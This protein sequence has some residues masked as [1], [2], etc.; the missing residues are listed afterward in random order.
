MRTTIDLGALLAEARGLTYKRD[1]SGVLMAFPPSRFPETL[2]PSI[3]AA[4]GEL[5]KSLE[6]RVVYV[7]IN[8]MPPGVVVPKHRDYLNAIR[9]INKPIVER[10][11]LPILTNSQATWWDELQPDE[12]ARHMPLGTWCGPVPYHKLHSVSNLGETDRIHL[13]VDTDRF[14]P[15]E[16]Y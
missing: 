1:D 3:A 7:Q 12:G 8:V 4:I 14:V 5:E 16:S 9:G 11:H 10:F 6:C 15:N 13:V 2:P